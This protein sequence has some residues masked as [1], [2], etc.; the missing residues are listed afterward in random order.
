MNEGSMIFLVLKL[1]F[2]IILFQ[3]CMMRR[4]KHNIADW[5]RL[6]PKSMM[7]TKLLFLSQTQRQIH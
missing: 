5:H 7:M 4:T 6:Y 1:P 2:N 3:T